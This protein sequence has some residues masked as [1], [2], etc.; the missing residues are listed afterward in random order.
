MSPVAVT[1]NPSL[2]P[3]EVD[4]D[5][6]VV[7]NASRPTRMMKMVVVQSGARDAYQLALALSERDILE[8]LVTDLFWPLDESWARSLL[9]ALPPVIRSMILPRSERRLPWHRIKLCWLVGMKTLL[10]E[11]L[12]WSSLDVRRR[13]MRQA[14]AVLGQ[15]AGALAKHKKV[16]LLS[17]SY[18]GYDAFKAYGQ[19]GMLFQLHPHPES[20]RRILSEELAAH[21]DC[22]D[23]LSQ[24][25]ELSL[26]EE[27]FQHLVH[28][29][30]MA[31][32]F[33]V[34]SSFTK[35]TL[36]ENGIRSS[37]VSVIP[38]GVD[39]TRFKPSLQSRSNH[40]GKLRLLF[41]G[42]INQRKG[43]KYLLEALRLVDRSEVELTV[44]GRV[45]DGLELFRPFAGR[46]QVRPS[47]SADELVAAYQAA[48]LFVFPSVAEGF[49]Q[50]LLESLACGLPILSTTHTAAPD[51]IDQGVQGFV[52][53]P[54]RPDL[55]AEKILWALE[56][57]NGLT[58]MGQAARARAEEF[59][60]ERFRSKVADSVE[61][62]LD[63]QNP[64]EPGW[65]DV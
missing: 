20:M 14:D 11:R 22:A 32:H 24:E 17:Y 61:D 13:A 36:V 42:R 57:R 31:S 63:R 30:R 62:Y 2:L 27:D 15:T 23:S 33:L 43:I 28:E 18:Y 46:V 47:V 6:G 5:F 49:G 7:Q 3:A 55:I 35:G 54:G 12:S 64:S 60:W 38:Y 21:P 44:C 40:Q 48:D 65:N 37:A 1:P 45:I 41:V 25:W 34:A 29:T 58:Q 8:T 52:V 19:P 39:T 16:G 50:V 56:H 4:A 59:T 9:R 10:L 51:L 26:P 53:D